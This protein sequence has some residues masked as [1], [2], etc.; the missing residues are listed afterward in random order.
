MYLKYKLMFI[1][2]GAP[3]GIAIGPQFTLKES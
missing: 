2:G 3:A 1:A